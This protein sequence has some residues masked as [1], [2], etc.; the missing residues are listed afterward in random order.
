[1]PPLRFPA[2][3]NPRRRGQW[4]VPELVRKGV[5]T[6]PEK[7][8]L[9]QEALCFVRECKGQQPEPLGGNRVSLNRK[10]LRGEE[11]VTPRCQRG[12]QPGVRAFV[13]L[14]LAYSERDSHHTLAGTSR[15]LCAGSTKGQLSMDITPQSKI[16]DVFQGEYLPSNLRITSKSTIR[17]YDVTFRQF[18]EYLG[19][20]ATLADLTDGNCTRFCR[21]LQDTKEISPQTIAQRMN[22][23]RAFWRWCSRLRYIEKWPNFHTAPVEKPLPR[24]WT[25][26]QIEALLKAFRETPGF[27]GSIPAGIWWHNLHRFAWQTGERVGAMLKARWDDVDVDRCLVEIPAKYRK[28]KCRGMLYTISEDLM[29]DLVAMRPG[30][31][32]LIFPFPHS[33]QTFYNRYAATL[34][35]AGLPS[36]HKS[37]MH[38]MRRSFASYLEAAGGNA[39]DALKHSRRSVTVDSYIDES[40]VDRTPA[41]KILPKLEG[42]E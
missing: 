2:L 34:N 41:F 11:I 37:K 3:T 30:D 38:R 40:I 35:R 14:G 7:N 31:E 12:F 13:V 33:E 17:H 5:E 29:A 18:N 21:W 6:R 32:P 20:P 24:A 42:G 28:G 19:R 36:D 8:H 10:P 9:A 27:V 15:F 4:A 16:R 23:V 39:T 22:Y 26:K 1:M 25:T